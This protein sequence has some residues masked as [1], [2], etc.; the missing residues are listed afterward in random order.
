M[1]SMDYNKDVLYNWVIIPVVADARKHD[2]NVL[3]AP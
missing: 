3:N 1:D 2:L